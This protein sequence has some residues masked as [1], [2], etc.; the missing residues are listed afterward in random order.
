MVCLEGQIPSSSAKKSLSEG[1]Q[2][3]GD[4]IPWKSAEQFRDMVFPTLSG[5]RI[6]HIATHPNAM[7][8]GYGS[9][10]V[11]LL[12]RYFEGQFTTRSEVDDEFASEI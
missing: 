4:Q 7:K 12:T 10:A 2:P 1:H 3:Y 6:V 11:E 9:T 5:A 8:L